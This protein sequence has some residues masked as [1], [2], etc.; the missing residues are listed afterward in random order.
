MV[1]LDGSVPCT[2]KIQRL[3]RGSRMRT[4]VRQFCALSLLI[5]AACGGN[6]QEDPSV[7]ASADA[8]DAHHHGMTATAGPGYTVADV[9]FM[10][11]MIGHHAQAITMAAMAGTHGAGPEVTSLARRV[12]ISQRDEIAFM[13]GWLAARGQEVPGADQLHG[14]VMPGLVTPEQ[15]ARLD[16]ARGA[17]FD[18]LFLTF[19]IEHHLGALQMVDNLFASP[20]AAQ[21]SELFPFATDVGA[22]QLD[23]IGIMERILDQ[24]DPSSRSESR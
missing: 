15:L 3:E 2:P 19:M 17:E 7:A 9:E 21:D 18:R 23:E 11:M 20:G 13:E 10:Q 1:G 24:L 6:G 16:A 12:D 14:M 8:H 22:D 5:A 4:T